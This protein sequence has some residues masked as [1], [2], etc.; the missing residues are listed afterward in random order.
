MTNTTQGSAP[1]VPAPFPTTNHIVAGKAGRDPSTPPD[2]LQK[3][4]QQHRLNR[5]HSYLPPLG[6]PK[7]CYLSSSCAENSIDGRP[8]KRHVGAP[9]RCRCELIQACLK[10]IHGR[11]STRNSGTSPFPAAPSPV[12]SHSE[13]TWED[14]SSRY[15]SALRSSAACWV[16]RFT[17]GRRIFLITNCF[18][19]DLLKDKPLRV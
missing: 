1:I 3:K 13:A 7:F 17:S 6:W 4:G 19:S 9:I 12:P 16:L 14:W 2:S 8:Q 18:T 5:G 11:S 15:C 10:T